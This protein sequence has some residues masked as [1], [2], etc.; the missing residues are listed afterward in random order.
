MLSVIADDAVSPA[1][2][3]AAPTSSKEDAASDAES[4]T[5]LAARSAA[6]PT[7]P[8]LACALA[9]MRAKIFSKVVAIRSRVASILAMSSAETP[10]AS[11][12]NSI[13][14]RPCAVDMTAR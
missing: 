11:A 1:F 12:S 2:A 14:A 5:V 6:C 8:M 9:S 3:A 13:R 4:D 10:E 7:P